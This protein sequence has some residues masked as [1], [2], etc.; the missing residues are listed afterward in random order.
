MKFEIGQTY[1]TT[2]TAD[3]DCVFEFTIVARTAK[4]ITF[5]QPGDSR[6]HRVGVTSYDGTEYAMP[7][8][9]YSMAPQ[10]CADRRWEM[11][12]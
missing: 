7:F 11:A 6:Q 2:S 9:R 5:V 12:A 4:F 10:I 1:W 3:A 8:G